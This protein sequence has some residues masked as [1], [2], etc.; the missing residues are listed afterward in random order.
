LVVVK[1]LPWITREK[2]SKKNGSV[3]RL[4]IE[5]EV[6]KNLISAEAK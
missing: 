1:Y 5:N 2:S 6:H 4:R 3:K